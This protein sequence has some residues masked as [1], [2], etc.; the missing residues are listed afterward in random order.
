M[1]RSSADTVDDGAGDVVMSTVA[2]NT[3]DGCCEN[4]GQVEVGFNDVPFRVGD[5]VV[6]WETAVLLD[7]TGLVDVTV[8]RGWVCLSRVTG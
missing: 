7:G 2:C 3:V 6:G 1:D 4:V 8:G 5:I